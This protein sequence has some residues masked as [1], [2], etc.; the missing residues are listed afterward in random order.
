MP[1]LLIDVE[2]GQCRTVLGPTNGPHTVMCGERALPGTSTCTACRARFYTRP[3]AATLKGL[4][5]NAGRPLKAR[6]A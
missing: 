4:D 3:T 6:G 2:H 1:V 5:W